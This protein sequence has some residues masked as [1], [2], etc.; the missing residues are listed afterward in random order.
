MPRSTRC[1]SA[2]RSGDAS[3]GSAPP[4]L[5][6]EAG[7][8]TDR[9]FAFAA[10][11]AAIGLAA[12][13]I[14]APEWGFVHTEPCALALA[15]V[16]WILVAYA[17]RA[18]RGEDGRAGRWLA[19]AAAGAALVAVTSLA[20]GLLGPDTRT[21]ARAPGTVVP[22]PDI[23]AAAFFPLV[24]ADGIA[25][26]DTSVI[27]RRRDR[28]E[29]DVPPGARSVV[30]VAVLAAEPH[31]AAYVEAYDAAGR[32][33][34]ITQPSNPTF[35]SP[36][37][38]FATTVEIAGRTL[39]ADAFATP[40]LHRQVSAVYID[41]RTGQG[42]GAHRFGDRSVVLFSVRDDRGQPLAQSIGFAASGDVARVAD[43]R[44]RVTIGSYPQLVIGAA[45]LPVALWIG[46][47]AICAGLALAWVPRRRRS[48][49]VPR[50]GEKRSA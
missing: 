37:L 9:L 38:Q 6:T 23:G 34:T 3:A 47:A 25:S 50:L 46:G 35:L 36:V 40:S 13:Q 24:D 32:R 4:L 17:A 14:E 43:L 15:L 49:T 31:I 19:L 30:G 11:A 16:V 29:L 22:L 48:E 8:V 5:G 41:A 1:C 44:L 21:V 33:L 26:G 28:A 12:A 18:A 20:A 42:L 39:P 7:I 10:A 2:R 45:P 27:L